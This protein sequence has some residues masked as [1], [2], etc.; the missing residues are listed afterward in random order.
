MT[1]NED[2]DQIVLVDEERTIVVSEELE[3]PEGTVPDE[4]G[5]TK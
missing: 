2:K 3:I 4:E 1:S 5:G